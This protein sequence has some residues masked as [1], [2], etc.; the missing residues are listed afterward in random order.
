[1]D[2]SRQGAKAPRKVKI[3]KSIRRW[4]GLPVALRSQKESLTPSRQD[5]KENSFLGVF[6]PWRET[7]SCHPIV[8]NTVNAG[9]HQF[10]TEID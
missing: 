6:A 3:K 7:L 8:N 9:L 1:M 4:H 2:N 5:T 10:F